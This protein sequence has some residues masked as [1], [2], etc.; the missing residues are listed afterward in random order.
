M[1]VGT[2]L[3]GEFLV[4]LLAAASLALLSLTAHA[5]S[6]AP[7]KVV[8]GSVELTY[9]SAGSGEPV[10]LLHGGQGDYRSW[11]P[12]MRE[13]SRYYHVISYSRRYNFP[14][15]NPQTANDHSVNTEAADLA[16][17]IKALRLKHV[18]L[19]GT[20]MGA[21]TALV[22]AIEHPGKVRSLVIAEPPILAWA[23]HFREGDALYVDFMRRI[24]DPAREAFATGD[25]AGAMRF[26]VDGFARPGRF[27][28]LSPEARL[29]VMQNAGFFRMMAR[30]GNPYPDLARGKLGN[31]RMP[32]LVITGEKTVDIYRRID[33]EL[34]RMIPRARSATIPAAGHG[35]PRENPGAFTEVVE[36]FLATSG[37]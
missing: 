28:G 35:S 9:I 18:N 27:D 13:L 2:W 8:V 21:A 32:V 7:R 19:V 34:S 20:S 16:A 6:P 36:N 30:S 24:H 26:F 31:L 11:E 33:E 29:G 1:P 23:K 3:L 17:L 5:Q 10:I 37:K 12:Q 14:N 4:R 15:V 25:D 22:F